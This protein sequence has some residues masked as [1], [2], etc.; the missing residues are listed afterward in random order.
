M[1]EIVKRTLAEQ[2]Y[3]RLRE[4]I[5][6]QNILCGEKI[7]IRYLVDRFKV[8][9]S[10]IREAMNRLYQDGLL[11]Y[12]T[13]SGAKVVS[14]NEKEINEIYDFYF[15][16]ECIAIKFAIKNTTYKDIALELEQN[17]IKQERFIHSEDVKLFENASD[18]FHIVFYNLASNSKLVKSVNTMRSQFSILTTKY[19]RYENKK[20]LV[21]EEHKEIYNAVKEEDY[22]KIISLMKKHLDNSKSYILSNLKTLGL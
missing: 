18:E 10:P 5:I 4:D 9:A 11:E 16:L 1:T 17:L 2:V 14:F 20:Y 15:E 8:S 3:I 13:N 21:Y 22:E 6:Q 7:N 12:Y 19:Q